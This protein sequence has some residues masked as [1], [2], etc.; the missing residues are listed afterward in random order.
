LA[1]SGRVE[2]DAQWS[3]D[4]SLVSFTRSPS[5]SDWSRASIWTVRGDGSGQTRLTAGQIARWA[6][7]GRTLVF[8]APTAE[9][10]GDLFSVSADGSLRQQL[11][12]TPEFESAAGFSPDG[13]TIL[14]T[15]FGAHQGGD[16]FVMAADGTNVRR[17]TRARGDDIA[18][19]WSPD[20]SQI[21]FTSERAGVTHLYLMDADGSHTRRVTR[22]ATNEFEPT[23]R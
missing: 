1:A 21:L 5:A 14:F 18:G 9:S 10:D 12:A 3:P 17:L 13:T 7:N 19:A 22:T 16:V 23:W 4:G 6:P 20:G 15:R 2:L 11:L 8:S